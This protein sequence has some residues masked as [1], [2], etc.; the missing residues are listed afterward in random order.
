MLEKILKVLSNG[1]VSKILSGVSN[2]TYRSILMLV[3]STG[4][5]VGEEVRLKIEDIDSRRKLIHIKGAKGRKDRYTMLSAIALQTL[6]EYWKKTQPQKWLFPGTKKGRHISIR[7]VQAIFGNAKEYAG[8]RKEVTV[9][10]LR[11]YEESH[12]K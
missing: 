6:R 1:E 12:P 3:Y 10:S 4:L 11:H 9:H 7:T 5:R 2:I 8:I